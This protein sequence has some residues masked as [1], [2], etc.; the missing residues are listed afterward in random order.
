MPVEKRRNTV[1]LVEG[2]TWGTAVAFP[3]LSGVYAQTMS[4]VNLERAEAPDQGAG[5]GIEANS[6]QGNA[7]PSPPL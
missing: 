5:Y 7:T 1:A 3:A 4:G 2:T 6:E